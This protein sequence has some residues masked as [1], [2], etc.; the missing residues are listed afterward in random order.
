MKFIDLFAGC[1]GLSLG[2]S[3]AGL[4]GVLAIE[5]SSD[6]FSSFSRNFLDSGEYDFYWPKDIEARAYTTKEF[7]DNNSRSLNQLKG[8]IDLIAGGPPCQGYSFA[9]NRNQHDPRNKLYHEY[10]QYVKI[11]KP[12][13]LLFENVKG[14]GI[15]FRKSNSSKDRSISHANI[16]KKELTK[17][18]YFV[19]SK[20]INSLSIGIP[21]SRIRY[22]I[23]AVR[24]DD[25]SLKYI[26][27]NFFDIFEESLISF[28]KD[29]MLNENV[30]TVKEAISDLETSHKKLI[31]C[32]DSDIKGFYQIK[33]RIDILPSAYQKY[34]RNGM[35]NGESP[36]SLRLVKHR[37]D[38][39]AKFKYIL[40]NFEKGKTLNSSDRKEINSLKHAF[41]PLSPE[42]AAPTVTTLPDDMLHYK[43]PRVLTVRE[44]ARLQSF[45]DWFSFRGKYT[46]G[47][48]YRREDCPRYTQVGNA[49]PPLLAEALG[50]TLL[51][52]A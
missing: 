9:G 10:I 3:Q 27:N 24:K 47:G 43:E 4:E 32:M 48:K 42:K 1:G 28:K 6:A 35:E 22:V 50:S 49:V 39:I 17:L 13:F 45:P 25:H 52:I 12:R 18:G 46:T 19:Q 30:T 15:G 21:Q 8:S 34:V 31:P 14:F 29:R 41:T 11:L 5:K 51:E 37:P 20:Q 23:F 26:K 7:L 16:V 36:N 40:A 33:Y 44:M 38:T 2:L